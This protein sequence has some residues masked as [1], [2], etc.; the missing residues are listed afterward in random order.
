LGGLRGGRAAAGKATLTRAGPRGQSAAVVS[1]DGSDAGFSDVRAFSPAVAA[2]GRTS[3]QFDQAGGRMSD[4]FFSAPDGDSKPRPGR[5]GNVGRGVRLAELFPDARFYAGDDIVAGGFSDQAARCRPG[6]VFVA[7][8]D[9]GRD[10]HDDIERALARGAIGVIADRMLPTF[11]TPLCVVDDTNRAAARLAHA[12]AGDPSRGMKVIA[13]TGTSGKTTT[14]WLTA[15][16]LA[17]A[18]LRV[19]VLSDLGCLAA[20]DAEPVAADL[21]RPQVLA[22]WLRRLRDDGCTHVVLEVSSA[23]LATHSLAGVVC[24]T[25]AVTNLAADHLDLHGTARAY[26][27]VT[28]RILD[29]LAPSGCLVAGIDDARVRRLSERFRAGGRGDRGEL[30][31][32]GLDAAAA[33]TATPV[34]RSLFGQTFL[35]TV[36]GQ[37][38]PVAVS[39][40]LASFARDVLLAVAVG[41]RQRVPL[42]RIARGIEA[43]GAVAGRVER[44]DC[45]QPHAAFLDHP[46]SG[47][48]LAATL[49]GLKH[50]TRG[51]L[52][53]VAEAGCAGRLVADAHAGRRGGRAADRSAAT[54]SRRTL[55]WADDCLVVPRTLLDDAAQPVDLLAYARLDRL[56]SGLAADDCLLVL[57]GLPM[58]G[59][60]PT[61]PDGDGDP[62]P[63][64][65]V[66]EGWLRLA[67]VPSSS[68]ANRHAA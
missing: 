51:R 53:V 59:R 35:L 8:L 13:I 11:G 21:A 26:R 55:R 6:D 50:L 32:A 20:D 62:L 14:A 60:G 58:R 7:R 34:E 24:D 4:E 65:T 49:A 68:A 66:I 47:H 64:A 23:M 39:T 63:L 3:G 16:V 33:V 52:V 15:S 43:A 12:L 5:R 56:L 19:G 31:T 30:I 9:G 41:L 29:A 44:I 27:A 17:E 36:S 22:G 40:P 46:T 45:G 61:G 10:G 42:E 57:G 48:G 1:K 28:S 18:G 67:H 37:V 54:F 2:T 25:V 38:M